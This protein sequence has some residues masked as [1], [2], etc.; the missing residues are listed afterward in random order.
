MKSENH[1]KGEKNSNI[2]KN[3]KIT[4]LIFV[5]MIF[6]VF[7]VGGISFTALNNM[8]V[9]SSDMNS[10]YKDRMLVSLDL[11]R[12]ET[13]FYIRRLNM[14]Q[15]LYAGQYN[16]EAARA[17]ADKQESLN[18]KIE[19]YKGFALNED[20]RRLLQNIESG[21]KS[22][23]KDAGQLL[24]ALKTGNAVSEAQINQLGAYA[25]DIQKNID[26]LV[27]LNAETAKG[28]VNK[29]NSGYESAKKTFIWLF[30][31]LTAVFIVYGL[32]LSRLIRGSMAQINDVLAKLAEYDFTVI[33]EEGG[34]SE[35]ARMN[36]S[37]AI[38]VDNLKRALKEVRENS[39]NVTGHSQSLA[40]VSEEMTSATQELATTMQQVAQGATS[41][42]Q[43]LQEIV[44]SLS[45][46]T[47]NI[48]NVYKELQKVKDETDT[49]AERA[50]KGK[51]EMDKL[52]KSINEIK[53]SF[54]VVVSKVTN[55]TGSVKQISGITEI[56]TGIADQTNLLALNAAIEA[57]R[58]GEHGRG[59]A[60]VADEVRK[61]A[62]E[63]RKSASEITNLVASINKD[64]DEVIKTSEDV[65]GF[66]KSQAQSV[67]QTVQ[68][69]GDITLSVE[70][71]APLMKKTYSAMDEIV[72]SKDQVMT[73]V[74]QVSAVTEENSAATEEVA[75]SSEELSAS[76]QE[77]ASTAQN[78]A[79]IAEGLMNTV[80]RF[81]V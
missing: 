36:S 67:G 70:N 35:F 27:A 42:A 21:Y 69:F 9:L 75:A 28:V 78:L 59:F 48:E 20:E 58:A 56:I 41:Q 3:V 43:D 16:E 47:Q 34:K 60:V 55:L 79:S 66:I 81:K 64:T 32:I 72:K 44:A 5:L 24:E 54:E 22:Y 37:L 76:S 57:A 18:K 71:I 12:L 53:N 25:A 31:V 51:G 26:E 11:K 63:S 38:V 19:E 14:T 23:I 62:E 17:V 13:E 7:A 30:V 49:T 29:A 39:E 2:L 33:L 73:R 10:L 8:K 61:L 1:S 80:N 74:E 52:I 77:V 15:M 6:T 65:E 45:E 68:S 40:A 46:L 4:T 50:N